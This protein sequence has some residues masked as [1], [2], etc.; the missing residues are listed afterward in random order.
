MLKAELVRNVKERAGLA[1]LA[2]AEAA[3]DSLLEVIAEVLKTEGS[4][5]L[6]GF[7]SFKVVSRAARKGR[8]PR[9]GEELTIPASKIVKF[10]PGK[11]LKEG[12]QRNTD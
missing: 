12:I 6:F 4:L 1:S 2:Q 3:Y 7:G 5:A 8:N 9:T 11:N 10:M